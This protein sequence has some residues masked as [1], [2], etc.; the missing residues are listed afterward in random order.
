MLLNISPGLHEGC[1]MK[2]FR[3]QEGILLK[4]VKCQK[5]DLI[6]VGRVDF[7][8]VYDIPADIIED[9]V[10]QNPSELSPCVF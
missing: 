7:R 6:L 5:S 2:T 1:V 8:N 9:Y 4:F 10:E 3:K